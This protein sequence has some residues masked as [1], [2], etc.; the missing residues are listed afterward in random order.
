MPDNIDVVAESTFQ[1][2]I[3]ENRRILWQGLLAGPVLYALYFIMV[4][5]LAEAACQQ[6]LFTATVSGLPLRS[7]FILIITLAVAFCTFVNGLSNYR[8]WR[9]QQAEHRLSGQQQQRQPNGE[10]A[11]AD[12][13]TSLHFMA[14]GGLLL[15]V[16]FTMMILY[17]GLPILV[18]QVCQWV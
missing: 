14:F 11:T 12:P 10:Y 4:Y 16:L 5:L 18:L 6:N 3:E 13:G 1:S 17:T 7:I 15:S 2:Q 8:R 9:E